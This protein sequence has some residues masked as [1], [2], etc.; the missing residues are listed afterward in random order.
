M[1]VPASDDSAAVC[2]RRKVKWVLCGIFA[3]EIVVCSAFQQWYMVTR[4][5]KE[6]NKIAARH[7]EAKNVSMRSLPQEQ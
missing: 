5:C 2:W 7:Y 4:F 3:A 1:N 6:L